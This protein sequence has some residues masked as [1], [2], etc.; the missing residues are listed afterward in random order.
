MSKIWDDLMETVERRIQA[1]IEVELENAQVERSVHPRRDTIT[2][3]K[4]TVNGEEQFH[5]VDF[6][7]PPCLSK[8]HLPL[9]RITRD[10][11]CPLHS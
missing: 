8:G 1:Y 10:D 9:P 2:V 6:D 3:L 11:P 5:Y 4:S 7:P